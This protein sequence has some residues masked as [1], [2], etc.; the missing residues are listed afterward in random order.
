MVLMRLISSENILGAQTQAILDA[1]MSLI[2]SKENIDITLKEVARLA[3]CSVHEV[4]QHFKDPIDIV[5][6]IF[7]SYLN[8]IRDGMKSNLATCTKW[9]DLDV[10]LHN[11]V[12]FFYDQ[13]KYDKTMRVIWQYFREYPKLNELEQRDIQLNSRL[14]AE[15]IHHFFPNADYEEIFNPVWLMIQSITH[16]ATAAQSMPEHDANQIATEFN[17]LLTL[18]I[19]SL[20]NET[21]EK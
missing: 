21:Q 17:R 6:V 10:A 1:A 3:G 20:H 5:A 11:V 9:E 7:E 12:R 15:H 4:Q 19:R 18:R 13:T 8:E 16:T 14:I 2:E